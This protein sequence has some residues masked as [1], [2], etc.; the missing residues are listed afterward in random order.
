MQPVQPDDEMRGD[1]NDTGGQDNAC[2]GHHQG[3]GS[4]LFQGVHG[5]A[6]AGVEQ[7]EGERNGADEISDAG[8][9]ELNAEPVRS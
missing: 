2:G 5:R 6:E 3:R 7:D 1:G 4:G 9:V 8:I